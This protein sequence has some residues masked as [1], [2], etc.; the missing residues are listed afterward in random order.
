MVKYSNYL[1]FYD[2][3]LLLFKSTFFIIIINII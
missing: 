2:N 3:N 1:V